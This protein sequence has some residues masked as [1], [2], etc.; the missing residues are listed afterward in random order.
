MPFMPMRFSSSASPS[1][2]PS[3]TG[4]SQLERLDPDAG[5]AGRVAHVGAHALRRGHG[6]P[7]RHP[8]GALGDLGMLELVEGEIGGLTD[9]R[10]IAAPADHAG[11]IIVVRDVDGVLAAV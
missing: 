5:R 1:S 4:P 9:E 7:L 11:D 3:P 8:G 10:A 6:V 2:C